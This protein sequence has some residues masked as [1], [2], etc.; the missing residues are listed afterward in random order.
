MS[1]LALVLPSPATNRPLSG[2]LNY[3]VMPRGAYGCEKRLFMT[4]TVVGEDI[5]GFGITKRSATTGS[6]ENSSQYA[7]RSFC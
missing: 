3:D 7:R 4:C 5:D 2:T 6:C 1:I